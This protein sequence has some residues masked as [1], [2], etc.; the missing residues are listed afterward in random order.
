MEKRLTVQD[1]ILKL[2]TESSELVFLT[3][4]FKFLGSEAQIS[5]ALKA[6]IEKAFIMRL[7]YGV[8]AKCKVLKNPRTNKDIS[9]PI[10]MIE[11]LAPIVLERLGVSIELTKSQEDYVSG[12]SQQIPNY[13][14]NTKNK[15][16][17]RKLKA[18]FSE[19]KYENNYQSRKRRN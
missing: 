7:G 5:R 9:V 13:I 10:K 19:I 2:V 6:I 16:V 3:R 1:K 8:Y 17:S 12:S 11:E 15:R 18:G 14:L 4:D